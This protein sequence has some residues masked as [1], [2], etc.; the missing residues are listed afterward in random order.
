VN[1]HH[2]LL[3]QLVLTCPATCRCVETKA[4]RV[5]PHLAGSGTTAG[6]H[7]AVNYSAES[8]S[9]AGALLATAFRTKIEEMLQGPVLL[10]PQ[11]LKAQFFLLL[12]D[13]PNSVK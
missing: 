1:G 9:A 10:T 12:Y 7:Y 4:G 5:K 13:V 8:A 2:R 11:E 3:V 6:W